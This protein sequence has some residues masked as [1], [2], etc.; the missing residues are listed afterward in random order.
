MRKS[1][2]IILSAAL[3]LVAVIA[4]AGCVSDETA[5]TVFYG[6]VIT[7]DDNNPTAEAV[8]VKDGIIVFVGSEA[9]AEKFIGEKTEIVDYGDYS[10]YPGFLEAH[11]HVG[12]AG[13]RDYG[14]AKLSSGV[15]LEENVKEIQKYIQDNPGKD[16]YIGSG[17]FFTGE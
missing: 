12:L 2:L 8:A 9:D 17:W 3:L 7:M 10:V 5:D 1:F 11:N 13:M 16:C 14:M 15:P 6:N 4:A